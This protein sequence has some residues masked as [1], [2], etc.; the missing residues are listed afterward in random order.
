MKHTLLLCALLVGQMAF[1]ANPQDEQTV[2]TAYAKL[3]FAVQSGTVY[4]EVEKHPKITTAE[5]AAKL[6]ANELRFDIT[7]M[8]SGNLSDIESRPYSDFVSKQDL[9]EVLHITHN[10]STLEENGMVYTSF[11][12]LPQWGIGG[13]GDEDWS[14]PVKTMMKLSGNEGKWPRYVTA[15]IT[16]SFQGRSRAYHALWLFSDS[17]VLVV[18]PVTGNNIVRSFL[19]DSAYPSVLTDTRLRSRAPVSDWLNSTQR[20]DASCKPGKLDV[21]CDLATLRCGVSAEDLR[22]TKP[23]PSAVAA[24]KEGL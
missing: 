5:L 3:A 21:C 13:E 20:F 10:V 6:Q 17:D 1:A 15:T 12:A 8:S 7:E 18:D 2:R 14:S 16:V 23:A 22:S 11:F 4:N 19:S 24:H 9:Q